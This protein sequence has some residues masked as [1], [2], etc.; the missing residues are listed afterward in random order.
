MGKFLNKIFLVIFIALF[1]TGIF[2]VDTAFAGTLSCSVTNAAACT[3]PNVVI[4]RMSSSS[5]A[6]AEL[7]SQSTAVY[8]NNVVCCGGVTGL[9]NSC[10]GS[11]TTVLKL[12]HATNAHVQQSGSYPESACISVPSGPAPIVAYVAGDQSCTPTYDTTL[13]SMVSADNSHVGNPTAYNA[14]SNY[15][16]CATAGFSAAI[17]IRAQNYTTSVSTIT[18]PQGA[19]ET[20]ISQPYN[21]QSETQ[22]FG[23]A[24]TAKPVVTLY[25]SGAST[26]KIWYN[27][28]TFTNDIVISEYYLVNNK[29]AACA[30][31]SCI[32][33]SVIFDTDTDTGITIAAGVGNEKD[34]YLKI[35]LS[36]I[37]GKTG[38]STLTILG[39]AL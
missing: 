20:T 7:P 26:L 15:K 38:N 8:A 23:G 36:A 1:I 29:G 22:I 6:H 33:N 4:L 25:N 27:I 39:E 30:N 32:S 37:A 14:A 35:V 13:L 16:V 18:F 17:D 12:A 2:F 5:N 24:G 9:S 10:S 34:F 19:P 28:S 31:E 11:Y 21:S 3:S